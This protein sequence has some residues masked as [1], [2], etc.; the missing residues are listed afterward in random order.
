MLFFK[1]GSLRAITMETDLVP[2]DIMTSK[3]SG[4]ASYTFIVQAEDRTVETEYVVNIII[5]APKT[6]NAN[7]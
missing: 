7:Y 5:T 6:S 1:E 2:G 3:V 4:V